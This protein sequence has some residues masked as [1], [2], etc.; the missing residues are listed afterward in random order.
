[1]GDTGNIDTCLSMMGLIALYGSDPWHASP[2][3]A[4]G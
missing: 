1:M 2:V 4:L 3:Q